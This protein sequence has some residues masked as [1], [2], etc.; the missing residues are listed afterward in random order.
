MLAYQ[1]EIDE[2]KYVTA[3]VDDWALLSL[4]ITASRPE[5][6]LSTCNELIECSVGGL[7]L[8]VEADPAHYHFRWSEAPLKVGSTVTIRIVDAVTADTPKK[9]YR[10]DSQIQEN[11]Y[12]TEENRQMRYQDY[13]SLKAEFEPTI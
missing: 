11:P 7:A 12:T 4:H 10:S 2:K 6:G 13:L 1:I 9:R 8:S 5:T 3:G